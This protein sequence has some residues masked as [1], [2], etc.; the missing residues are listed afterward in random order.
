[1]SPVRG[2]SM[3]SVEWHI[4]FRPLQGGGYE[5]IRVHPGLEPTRSTTY[6]LVITVPD[7]ELLPTASAM[8]EP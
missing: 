8:V 5:V 1:M 4:Q 6:R 7:A 2:V 3:Q